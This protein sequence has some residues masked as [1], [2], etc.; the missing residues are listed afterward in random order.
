MEEPIQLENNYAAPRPLFP[1]FQPKNDSS[2]T[3][4]LIFASEEVYDQKVNAHSQKLLVSVIDKEKQ[5]CCILGYDLIWTKQLISHDISSMT[6]IFLRDGL[7]F[8]K[9]YLTS[10][11]NIPSFIFWN[12]DGIRFCIELPAKQFNPNLSSDLMYSH[13]QRYQLASQNEKVDSILTHIHFKELVA[14]QVNPKSLFKKKRTYFTI[15]EKKQMLEDQT[16]SVMNMLP[17]GAHQNNEDI[18][19]CKEE[20]RGQCKADFL[21]GQT[22]RFIDTLREMPKVSAGLPRSLIGELINNGGT[23][24]KRD[25]EQKMILRQYGEMTQD[26]YRS[27]ALMACLEADPP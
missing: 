10:K 26:L 8:D 20:F 1:E 11:E 25:L 15:N 18:F 21:Y 23:K 12:A 3:S 17:E 5:I 9:A 19:Q 24:L 2:V 13:Y 4:S 27:C 7:T 16:K 6:T 14:G 22:K